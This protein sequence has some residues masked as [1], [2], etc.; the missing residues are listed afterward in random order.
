MDAARVTRELSR[1]L[2]DLARSLERSSYEVERVA[3]LLKRCLFTMFS[4]DVGLI[5]DGQFTAL[6]ERLQETP[7]NF[8]NAIESL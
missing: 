3:H 6:L 5:P 2:S 4:E 8:P 7:E 1:T